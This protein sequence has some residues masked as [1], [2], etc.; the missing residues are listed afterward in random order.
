M[1]KAVASSHPFDAVDAHL[2]SS[3]KPAI[4]A[5]SLSR[6][7]DLSSAEGNRSVTHCAGHGTTIDTA[8]QCLPRGEHTRSWVQPQLK[9]RWRQ[10]SNVAANCRLDGA[11]LLQ[12]TPESV[13]GEH[14][15][16]SMLP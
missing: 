6:D 7:A 1:S 13:Q 8:T 3:A 10:Q 9:V 12:I 2:H 5:C 16:C 14:P 11:P 4:D 15:P